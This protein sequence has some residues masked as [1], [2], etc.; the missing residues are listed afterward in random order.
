MNNCPSCS[1]NIDSFSFSLFMFP[2]YFKCPN[3]SLRLRLKSAKL[4]W[5]TFL[6]YLL[7]IVV[8]I[9][10]IPFFTEYNVGVILSVSGWFAVYYKVAP[11]ILRKDNLELYQ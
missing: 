4:I 5:F 10:Y 2:F 3:C 8:L 1:Q 11:Y 7:L 6:L 9:I